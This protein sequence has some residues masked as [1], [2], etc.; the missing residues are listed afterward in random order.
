[1]PKG[2]RIGFLPATILYAVLN[3]L[4]DTL[5]TMTRPSAVRYT[6]YDVEAARKMLERK[7]RRYRQLGQTKYSQALGR[8][9][10][11][12]YLKLVQDGEKVLIS[13]TDDGI[14][15]GLKRV[16]C[17][18][19]KN[20]TRG[21]L[22]CVSFDIPQSAKDVRPLLR[23]LLKA[24]GFIMLQQSL[25]CSRKDVTKQLAAF[26]RMI[27]AERWVYVFEADHIAPPVR[28]QQNR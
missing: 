18:Q 8:L 7:E 15:L 22:C 26:I 20:L 27:G 21:Q 3:E 9:E 16:I 4:G 10:K 6:G 14:T 28:K 11:Q 5:F 12:N 13:L 24:S 23:N 2:L 19:K 1:M 25:W 17:A